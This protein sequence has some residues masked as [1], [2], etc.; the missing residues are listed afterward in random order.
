MMSRVLLGFNADDNLPCCRGF[1]EAIVVVHFVLVVLNF[2]LEVGH[3]SER[4]AQDIN[5]TY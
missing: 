3:K 1:I 5:M 4:K 2:V